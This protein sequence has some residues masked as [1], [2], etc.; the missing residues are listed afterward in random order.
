MTAKALT[1]SIVSEDSDLLRDC[2][3]WLSAFGYQ[4]QTL[5]HTELL[6]KVWPRWRPDFLIV[7]E[8]HPR[9]ELAANLPQESA[10]RFTYRMLLKSLDT[11]A[12]ASR[13]FEFAFNDVLAK[14]LN[15]GEALARLRAGARFIELERRTRGRAIRDASTGLLTRRGWMRTLQRQA[16]RGL[17]SASFGF[18]LIGVDFLDPLA[19]CFGP[20]AQDEIASGIAARIS[21]LSSEAVISGRLSGGQFGL[22]WPGQTADRCERLARA[23][24]EDLAAR[25]LEV[26][27]ETLSAAVTCCVGAWRCHGEPLA[28]V[29]RDAERTLEHARTLGGDAICRAGQFDAEFAA[30]TQDNVQSGVALAQ[31]HA[32]DVMTP[33]SLTLSSEPNLELL[34]QAL[35]SGVESIAQVDAEGKYVGMLTVGAS[36]QYSDA[37]PSIETPCTVAED[38]TFAELVDKLTTDDLRVVVVSEEGSPLGYVSC[39]CMASLLEPVH[40]ETFQE[41]EWT[42]DDSAPLSISA[43]AGLS[44]HAAPL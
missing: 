19:Q 36:E 29:V 30:W 4:V 25:P 20:L 11:V 12:E 40:D 27:G 34:E 21:D 10:D 38:A 13:D 17:S 3:W 39:G 7:D 5:R 43:V 6:E 35:H 22:A 2:S 8:V 42:D 23:L 18:T 41:A 24:S 14:P 37:R 33:F 15:H 32:R 9:L 28:D 44:T 26:F 31:L 16:A 1:V